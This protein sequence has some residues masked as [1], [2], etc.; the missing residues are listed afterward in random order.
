MAKH[1][2]A[3]RKGHAKGEAGTPVTGGGVEALLSNGDQVVGV[4]R[5]HVDGHLLHP[6]LKRKSTSRAAQ[7]RNSKSDK[8]PL[9]NAAD[10]PMPGTSM[11]PWTGTSLLAR[12]SAQGWCWRDSPQQAGTHQRGSLMRSQ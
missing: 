7:S 3:Q 12:V 1:N 11:Q 6:L 2:C 9:N 10:A 4:N 5:L 8:C